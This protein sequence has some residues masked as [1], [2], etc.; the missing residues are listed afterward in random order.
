MMMSFAHVD[1]MIE[2]SQGWC[3]AG[4]LVICGVD[5]YRSTE[6]VLARFGWGVCHAKT[7]VARALSLLS[8]AQRSLSIYNLLALYF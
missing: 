1:S 8:A 4:W 7:L 2:Q 5:V 6:C 3:C